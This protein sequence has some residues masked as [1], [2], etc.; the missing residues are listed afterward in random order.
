[1]TAIIDIHHLSFEFADHQPVLDQ[2][3]VQFQPRQVAL[4]M[5][6]SGCGKSTLLRLIAGLLPKYGGKVTSGQVAFPAGAPTIGMLFQDPLTQFALDTPRH[7]L[8]FVLENEQVAPSQISHR[9]AAALAFCNI[10][11]LADRPLTTL[12]GGQQQ[13]VALAVVI[14]RHAQ[15]LLLDE[16]FASIDEGNRNF[17]IQQLTTL[18]KTGVTILIADHDCH[19]YQAL[20]PTVYHFTERQVNQLSPKDSA[21][22]LTAADTQAQQALVTPLP[23]GPTALEL[24]QVAISRGPQQLLTI[25]QLR[26]IEGKITLLTGPNGSGKSTFLKALARLLPYQGQIT[27]LGTDIQTIRRRQYRHELGLVFQH[28]NDQFLN[29]TVGEEL[30][31]S[32]RNGNHPYFKDHLATALKLLGL[33]GLK[34]RVVYSLSGGQRKKLQ[35]LVMLMMGQ[36]VLLLDEPFAGLDQ[37]SFAAVC[38]L[39]RQAQVARPQTMVVIS[40]QLAAIDQLVDFHLALTNHQLSYQRGGRYESE[41]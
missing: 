37:Q 15:V 22:L 41:S 28:A 8:E 11:A 26:L 29:V 31:L 14:A 16:P 12:S 32:Q 40:H 33:A 25:P 10:A 34:S 21:A 24:N 19:G 18:V 20:T 1:M 6:P 30:T 5:G 36:S 38:Q 2:V 13:R 35:L 9:V 7:E 23:T 3:S 4:L 39:I 17:I 27:Y